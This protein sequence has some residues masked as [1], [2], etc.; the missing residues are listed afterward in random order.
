MMLNRT[1]L[2]LSMILATDPCSP[3]VVTERW[4]H[5]SMRMQTTNLKRPLHYS[6][7]Y[8]NSIQNESSIYSGLIQTIL[9]LFFKFRLKFELVFF[10][11][12]T[13]YWIWIYDRLDLCQCL[14]KLSIWITVFTIQTVCFKHIEFNKIHLA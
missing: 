14:N 11:W 2:L 7:H 1:K 10:F 13:F 8:W 5:A 3:T 6:K 9:K 12:N 4:R